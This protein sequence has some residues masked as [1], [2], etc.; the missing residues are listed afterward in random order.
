ML[1]VFYKFVSKFRNGRLKMALTSHIAKS[2]RVGTLLNRLYL[3]QATRG[4]GF[5]APRTLKRAEE[6]AAKTRIKLK[7]EVKRFSVVV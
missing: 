3:Q 1:Y 4:P 5:S 6:L 2:I 7:N